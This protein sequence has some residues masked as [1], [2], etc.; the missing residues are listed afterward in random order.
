M[1][2]FPNGIFS[3]TIIASVIPGAGIVRTMEWTLLLSVLSLPGVFAGAWL[4]KYTGRRYLLVMGFLGYIVF[5]LIVGIA[6]DQITKTLPAFIIMYGLMQMSGNFGL[7]TWKA[8]SVCASLLQKMLVTSCLHQQ[9]PPSRTRPASEHMLRS[10]RR[11]RQGR[12]PSSAPSPSAGPAYVPRRHWE[13]QLTV[14]ESLGKRYTFIIAACCGLLGVLLAWFCV[15]DKGRDRLEKED[16]AWRQY[17][18]EHGYSDIQMGDGTNGTKD[19]S[20]NKEKEA[21]EF[22]N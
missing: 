4:V 3:S 9:Q 7:A 12:A 21:L 16:E 2:T 10:V 17:L 13:A 20:A 11:D 1:V 22:D 15:E 18:V 5:G 8:P 14:A 19:A 6:Y